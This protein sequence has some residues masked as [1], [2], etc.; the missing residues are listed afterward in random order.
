[1]ADKTYYD[2]PNFLIVR[3]D[4]KSG[5]ISCPSSGTCFVGST[6]KTYT[7][8]LVVGA[9]IIV[10]S[11]GSVGGTVSLSI[12]QGEV[13]GSTSVKQAW[14][15]T[16][17][18]GASA[19]NDILNLS[20]T[21]GFTLASVGDFAALGAVAATLA[22]KCPVLKDIVWRYKILPEQLDAL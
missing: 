10:G 22:D 13:G 3:E 16:L 17:S 5:T 6:L 4:K 15:T 7:K 14:V 9:S 21:A 19:A 12:R 2:H 11:G 8:A 1:M 18:A 20:L